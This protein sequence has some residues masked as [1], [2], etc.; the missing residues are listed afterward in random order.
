MS[1]ER[2]P[3]WVGALLGLA[4]MTVGLGL[5]ELIAGLVDSWA[6]PVVSVGDRVID[7]SPAWLKD[8]AIDALGTND[9]PALVIGT[10]ILL[11]LVAV[12]LGMWAC[13]GKLKLALAGVAGFAVVGWAAASFDR[14]DSNLLA[15]M[16]AV[17]GGL[18]AAATMA[19]L[20][21]TLQ[22]DPAHGG[23]PVA[24]ST[25]KLHGQPLPPQQ[26]PAPEPQ[27]L[28]EP[29]VVTDG[30]EP[31]PATPAFD[32]AMDRI[33]AKPSRR[34]FLLGVG[35]AGA[36]ALTA[37]AA[38]RWLRQRASVAKE[39]A[40]VVLGRPASV[41]PTPP[42]D[43]AATTPGLSKLLTPNKDFYRIDTALTVPNVSTDSWT[44]RIHGM[45]DKELTLTYDQLLKRELFEFDHMLSCVSNTVGGDLAGSARWVGI[46]LDDLLNEAGIQPGADQIMGRSVDG[47]TAGFPT[48][49]LDGRDSIIAVGMNGEPLPIS[50]GYPARLVVP[51]LYGYVSATK[52]LKEIEL[53]TFADQEGYWIPRGWA[54]EAPIK[55]QSRID[56]PKQS[57]DAGTV[58]VA[59]VAWAPLAGV[60]KVEVQVDDGGWRTAT[61]GPELSGTTWRQWW[62]D[63]NAKSG[64]YLLR[65]RATDKDG[66]VQTAQVAPPRPDGATGYHEVQVSVS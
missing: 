51:G 7:G 50:H 38:G 53:T 22:P 11:G 2:Q 55:I 66:N 29:R 31:A 56:T 12:L 48:A 19:A 37:G 20:T 63:W 59:G 30:Y 64:T 25:G 62:T 65:C 34:S 4:S 6:S 5:G 9:K 14:A 28:D 43:P 8:F 13:N 35:A 24:T 21:R 45:V 40:A 32:E 49:V 57:I 23:P 47:F 46:R 60:A 3:R 33:G 17:L 41:L 16:P 42:A 52:W 26:A 36:L 61:L 54:V 18:A 58:A 15:G 39:R 27:L 10:L 44:L 1:T